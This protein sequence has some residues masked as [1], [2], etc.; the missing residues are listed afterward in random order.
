MQKTR[1]GCLGDCN[2]PHTL[3]HFI[4]NTADQDTSGRLVELLCRAEWVGAEQ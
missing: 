2:D 1:D 4:A 3:P